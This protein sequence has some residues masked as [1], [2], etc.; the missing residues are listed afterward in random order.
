MLWQRGKA[1]SQDL[2]ERVLV[3]GDEGVRVGQIASMLRVSISYVSKVLGRRRK[4]GETT[5][6]P[7][8]NHVPPKLRDYDQAIRVKLEAAPDLTLA[9][10]QAWLGK[11]HEVSISLRGIW[12]A[13]LRLG[14]TRKKRPNMRPSRAAL[15]SPPPA[16]H[17][18]APT[19]PG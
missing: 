9:E 10:L 14:L 17:G 16:W 4:T 5:A 2:R 3:A 19:S 13:L 8:I 7:Q 1:Y 15:T 12:K 6:R 11:E 18:H